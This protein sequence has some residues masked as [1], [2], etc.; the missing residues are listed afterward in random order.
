MSLTRIYKILTPKNGINSKF[1]CNLLIRTAKFDEL[2]FPGNLF[3]YTLCISKMSSKNSLEKFWLIVRKHVPLQPILQKSIKIAVMQRLKF[4]ILGG[5]N[6]QS[7]WCLECDSYMHTSSI[8]APRYSDRK[9][10][11][12]A[13]G[14]SGLLLT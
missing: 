7:T 8:A 9:T 13:R 5:L 10:F 11:H 14:G 4:N 3:L 1:A 2:A 6:I 12:I